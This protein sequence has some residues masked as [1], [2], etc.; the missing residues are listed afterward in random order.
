MIHIQ[1]QNISPDQ[2]PDRACSTVPTQVFFPGSIPGADL[3]AKA[4]C[5]GCP[6]LRACADWALTAGLTFGVVAAVRMPNEGGGR[7]VALAELAQIAATG[8]LPGVG[9]AA[10]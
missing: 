3:Q 1:L 5:A 8:Q 4:I 6:R 9:E 10:A 2:W 7:R